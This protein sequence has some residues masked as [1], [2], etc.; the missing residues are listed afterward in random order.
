MTTWPG[1]LVDIREKRKAYKGLWLR[2]MKE[3]TNKNQDDNIK[4][5]LKEMGGV[6]MDWIHL[7]QNR[8]KWWALVNIVMNLRVP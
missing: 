2:N 8:G 3:I 6:G 4:M 7:T 5:H 1:H